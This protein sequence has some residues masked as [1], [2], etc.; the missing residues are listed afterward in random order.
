MRVI[1]ISL[2]IAG[3]STTAANTPPTL[4]VTSPD[5]GTLSQ[6]GQV[7]V[8]G[9]VTGSTALHVTVNGTDTPIAADGTFSAPITLPPGLDLVETHVI[10]A[11]NND[12]RDVRA[13]LTGTLAAADGKVAAPVGARA[14]T[15]ALTAIGNTMAD[16]AKAIDFTQAVQSLNPIYNDSGCLG[17]VINVTDVGLSDIDVAITPHVGALTTEVVLDNVVVH[18]HASFRV[19]CI[20]GSTTITLKATKAHVKGDLG[21]A[22]TSGKLATS[23]PNASVTLDGFSL[24]IGGIPGALEDLVKGKVQDGVQS[25]LTSVVRSKV[26]PIANTTLAS[27]LAKPYTAMV[28][29]QQVKATV[30]PTQASVSLAGLYVAV[31]THLTVT[32]GEGGMYLTAPAKISE[33]VMSTDRGIGVAI[34]GDAVNQMFA[35]LWATKAL[36]QK[37][38]TASV[39]ALA[40][41]LDPDASSV[42]LELKLPPTATIGTNLA[43]AVGDVIIT[44]ADASGAQLQQIALSLS[45]TLSAGPTQSGK[46]DLQLGTPTVYAQVLA[47]SDDIARP[48]TDD[49]VEG[50]VTAVWGILG[51]AAGGALNKLPMPT[52][53]SI[54]LGE[55]KV[56]ANGGFVV[57]DIDVP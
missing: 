52:I 12:V 21:V 55:P 42:S 45:T 28:L 5:R 23:L 25:A 34:A 38:T 3:C 13:V 39:P 33:A 40:A 15:G 53:D 11:N 20:G 44:V 32:G 57:A 43:L 29:G 4:D 16:A 49:Q 51:P 8:T 35:G 22:V 17:A 48:L 24:D 7:T 30:T 56:S 19:A 9:S 14:G 54:Q 1:A 6:D 46:L 47:Q 2:V 26:P 18:L 10:D 31:D 41:I 36:D 50:L 37:F 27:L